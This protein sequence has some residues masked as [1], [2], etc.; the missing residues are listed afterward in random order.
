MS[1]NVAAVAWLEQ[2]YRIKGFKILSYNLKANGKIEHP[3]WDVRQMLYKATGG[4]LSQWFYFFHHVMWSDRMSVGKGYGCSPFFMLTGAHPTL[5]LDIQEGYMS[6][7]KDFTF[8]TGDLV[9]VRNTEIESSLDK[10]MKPRYNE[11]MV[12]I[13][14]TCGGLYVL[15]E[16]DGVVLHQKVGAFRIDLPDNIHELIDVI[17]QAEDVDKELPEKDFSFENV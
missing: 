6:T 4:N 16:L 7:I 17:E 3:H 14:R 1:D 15:A 12:V 11:P 2:K 5:P 10:K 8:Q 13:S 9:L